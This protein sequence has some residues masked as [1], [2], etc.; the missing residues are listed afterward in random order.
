MTPPVRFLAL[1]IGGWAAVRALSLVPGTDAAQDR[2]REVSATSRTEPQDAPAHG[3]SGEG[4]TP[5]GGDRALPGAR[6]PRPANGWP[7]LGRRVAQ[8]LRPAG[9]FR[10]GKGRSVLLAGAPPIGAG[11][12]PAAAPDRAP[13]VAAVPRSRNGLFPEPAL[14]SPLLPPASLSPI[15]PADRLSVDAWMLAR[16][17]DGAGALAAGDALLGGSQVGARWL[18][19]VAGDAGAPLSLS[20]RLSSPLRRSGAEAAVGVEWQPLARVP[21]RVLAERRA[22]VSGTGRSAFALLA[23]GGVSEL[24]VASGFRLDAYAQAG[25]VGARRR[26]LFADGGATL[27]RP[28]RPGG[29]GLA[30]GVGVWGGVQPGVARLDVGPRLATT[31][32]AGGLRSRVSLDWRF[33]VAGDAAPASGPALTVAAGF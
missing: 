22:R 33:R 8:P 14:V 18:Y 20:A 30:A 26:D 17:G 13:R 25:V 12:V 15:R 32:S 21:V 11:L 9:G 28:L 7:V 5:G 29:D 24:A 31:F 19:R 10:Y 1:V 4:P 2:P 16:R 3:A 23:H 27:V 6:S